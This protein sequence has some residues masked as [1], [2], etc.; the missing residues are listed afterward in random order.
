MVVDENSPIVSLHTN[1][2]DDLEIM[3]YGGFKTSMSSVSTLVIG[4]GF[5]RVNCPFHLGIWWM[6]SR[7][8]IIVMTKIK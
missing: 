3:I 5:T 4:W 1:G 7:R 6:G 8:A 2:F